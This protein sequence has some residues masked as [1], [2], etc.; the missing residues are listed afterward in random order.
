MR[1]NRVYLPVGAVDKREDFE[2][3]YADGDEEIVYAN[4]YPDELG[5]QMLA[6]TDVKLRVYERQSKDVR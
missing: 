1:N 5:S 4:P 3:Y 6:E 2:L